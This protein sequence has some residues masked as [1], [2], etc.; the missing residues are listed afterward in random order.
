MFLALLI[1]VLSGRVQVLFLIYIGNITFLNPKVQIHFGDLL[2]QSQP[3]HHL[4]HLEFECFSM[5][6]NLCVVETLLE[7]LTGTKTL[8]KSE[9]KL[10]ISTL[11]HIVV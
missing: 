7:Y 3:N 8:R 1:H 9:T 10:L 11:N 5:D 4:T 2:K 6:T